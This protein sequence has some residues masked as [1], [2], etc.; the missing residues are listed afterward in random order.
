MET[1]E[2]TRPLIETLPMQM[3]T[4]AMAKRKGIDAGQFRHI[5]KVTARE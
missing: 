5:S 4:L 2:L 1:S 3:L